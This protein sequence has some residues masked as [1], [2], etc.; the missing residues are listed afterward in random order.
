MKPGSNYYLG[1]DVG[2]SNTGI[3]VVR[4]SGELVVSTKISTDVRRGP[5]QLVSMIGETARRLMDECCAEVRLVGMGTPGPLDTHKGIVLEMPNLG[6]KNVPLGQMVQEELGITTYLDNDANAAAFGEWWVGAGVGA[7]VLVCFTL[8]TGVGGG[9]VIDG[10]VFRG[11][12][13]AAAEFGHM[14]IQLNG[15]VCKCG[16]RGC[17]EAYAS[18]SA[19]ASRAR[20]RAEA[21]DLPALLELAGGEVSR[22]TS[23]MVSQSALEGDRFAQKIMEETAS[24]LA[25]G[26]SNVMNAL[27]PDVVVIGGGV[28]GAGDMILEPLRRFVR[29]LTFEAIDD[30]ARIVPAKLGREAGVIGAA[31]IAMMREESLR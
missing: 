24:Y 2:G 26:V 23:E 16:K 9:I 10:S 8:G 7:R 21:G 12:K 6:W 5:K 1:I 20:E 17:L 22:I 3:G 18:A 30:S 29:E 28:M 15:R 13:G 31:G 25:I 19:I 14:I 11:V 27:N 4:P